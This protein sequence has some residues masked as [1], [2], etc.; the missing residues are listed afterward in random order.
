[1][2]YAGDWNFCSA[3]NTFL[4]KTLHLSVSLFQVAALSNLHFSPQA[5]G[6]RGVWL[7]GGRGGEGEDERGREQRRAEVAERDGQ[8]RG[9]QDAGLWRGWGVTT[10]DH[11]AADAPT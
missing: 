8:V 2:R 10:T 9:A 6:G 5:R 11:W 4:T 3:S 1:M 7:R